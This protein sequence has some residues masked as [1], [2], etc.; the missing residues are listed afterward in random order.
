MGTYILIFFMGGYYINH[1][2]TIGSIEFNSL[3]SCKAAGE[4]MSQW[5]GK[6]NLELACVKK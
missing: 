4:L 2:I 5:K 6:R 3:E 1:P